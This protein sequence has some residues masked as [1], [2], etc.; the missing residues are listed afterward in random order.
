MIDMVV[1]R[2]E[3]RATL[4]RLLGL[5]MRPTVEVSATEGADAKAAE[6]VSLAVIGS[7]VAPPAPDGPDDEAMEHRPADDEL[8]Q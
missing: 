5:L 4:A 8:R 3:L 7:E 6:P 1:H 2:F